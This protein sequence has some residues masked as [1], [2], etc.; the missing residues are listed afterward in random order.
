ME[1]G[2]FSNPS[3]RNPEKLLQAIFVKGDDDEHGSQ[4][5]ERH[6]SGKKFSA[7]ALPNHIIIIHL[8]VELQYKA[9]QVVIGWELAWEEQFDE[10]QGW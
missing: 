8:Q 9:V 4:R 6:E 5:R 1:E 7:G 2:A 10:K 3:L